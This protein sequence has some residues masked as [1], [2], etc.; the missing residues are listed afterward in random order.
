GEW[1]NS[2]VP[3]GLDSALDLSPALKRWAKFGRPS[4]AGF[5]AQGGRP[6]PKTGSYEALILPQT[7]RAPRLFL[8]REQRRRRS[9][10]RP[11]RDSARSPPSPERGSPATGPPELVPT[12]AGTEPTQRKNIRKLLPR[13]PATSKADSESTL[14][15]REIPPCSPFSRESPR[16]RIEKDR[17]FQA[18]E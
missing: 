11:L 5:S 2:V 1:A 6:P 7:V 10:S 13:L 12:S 9:G 3:P 8:M 18:E 16:P 15:R 17:S 4:G 14:L